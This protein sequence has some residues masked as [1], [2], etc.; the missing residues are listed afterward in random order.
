MNSPESSLHILVPQTVDERIHHGGDQSI[1][2]H[3]HLVLLSRGCGGGLQGAPGNQR[4]REPA[5]RGIKI[6]NQAEEGVDTPG[7]PDPQNRGNFVYLV[8]S[9]GENSLQ[10]WRR[11]VW[12]LSRGLPFKLG[13]GIFIHN[14]GQ[15]QLLQR[16]PSLD[17]VRS[18]RK[19]KKKKK[20]CL[21]Y[22]KIN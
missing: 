11:W 15:E 3:Y 7:N 1:E 20:Q 18:Y 2:D 17:S 16:F 19:K 9:M 21:N 4:Q 13:G 12:N 6:T 22:T 5:S 10:S 8:H 14:G